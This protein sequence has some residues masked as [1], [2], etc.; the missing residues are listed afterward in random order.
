MLEKELEAAI[1][2][3]QKASETILEYYALEIISEQKLGVDNHYEPVTAA[4]R[5]ASR[6]IV[7][8][9]A[10]AFPNDAILSEEETDDTENRL[11][12][13][14]VW[15]ID[16]IDGTA[17]FVKKDGDFAVQIGLAIASEAVLGVVLLPFHEKLFYAVKGLGTY[18]VDHGGEPQK[19]KA[20]KKTDF[21]EMTLAYSRNHPSPGISRIL[22]DFE[23]R[24]GVQRGSVGLKIG[25]IAEQVCDLYIHLSPRTKLWDTCAPQIILEEAGGKLTDLFGQKF[26]YDVADLQNYGGIVASNGASHDLALAKLR[27]LLIEFGRHRILAKTN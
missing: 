21:G 16:P 6:I 27:P 24:G 14:R 5:A 2:L 8:G 19:L 4:D 20:S 3:A 22:D 10:E 13:D 23:F 18:V 7:D 25:L 26:R 15:I 17:G 1:G 11:S 12:K 9:L